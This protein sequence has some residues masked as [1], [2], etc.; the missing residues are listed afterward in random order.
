MSTDYFIGLMSGTSMDAI[1]AA[2]VDFS[3]DTPKLINA[4]NFPIPD[5]LRTELQA[6]CQPG[7]NEIERLGRA[8][9]Q[10]GKLFADAV[11]QL[12]NKSNLAA[13][14]ICAIGSHG[15]TIRHAP[16]GSGLKGMNPF[17]LQIGDANQIAER[18][19]ITTVADFRRR[20][21]AA[22]GQ[23]APLVP[24]FH[25]AVFQSSKQT[26]VILNI[27]GIANITVL[28][29][30][31][32]AVI[33][34]FDTGPGNGLMDAWIQ[35]HQ[36]QNFDQDGKWASSGNIN[37]KLLTQL[38]NN[39][40]FAKAPPKSTGRELFNLSWLEQQISQVSENI[41]EADVQTTLAKFTAV[42]IADA[43]NQHAFNEHGTGTDEVIVCG[44]GTRNGFLMKCLREH[45]K[46]IE[47]KTTDELGLPAEWVE[48]VAF[49]WLA[50]E[51]LA[52]RPGN[53]PGV[54]GASHPVV[55]GGIYPAP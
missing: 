35:K 17:T 29:K 10:L 19:G 53:V 43:I 6:L 51:T 46:P 16:E 12:L 28:P 22:G 11:D 49:A 45:L 24:A 4:L 32:N 55:L 9:T 50:R 42:S 8:D 5:S 14:N 39:D 48:A 52:N 23:G 21:M 3:N 20:D 33:S 13:E 36:Q 30:T 47:V 44:G 1:D 26:R 7:E 54:T 31:K 27:G 41:T 15:Q 40:Y 2:L 25:A 34:G 37:K 38:L 18:T